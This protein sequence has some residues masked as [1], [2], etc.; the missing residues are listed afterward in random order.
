MDYFV[1][2]L[3]CHAA[4]AARKDGK[5]IVASDLVIASGAKQSRT[6]DYVVP[7]LLFWIATPLKRLAKTG[8]PLRDIRRR[9]KKL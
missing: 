7:E 6:I 2:I 5:S 8:Y 3:D 9:C 1:V 4:K